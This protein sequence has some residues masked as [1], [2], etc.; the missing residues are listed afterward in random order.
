MSFFLVRSIF[1]RLHQKK[2]QSRALFK[3]LFC[4]GFRF[5]NMTKIKTSILFIRYHNITK[6]EQKIEKWLKKMLKKE[7]HNIVSCKY[8]DADFFIIKEEVKL[9]TE[10]NL[11][12]VVFVFGK[13]GLRKKDITLEIMKP[14]FDKRMYSF[15]HI[16][17][18]VIFDLIDS[19]AIHLR[20]MAGIKNETLIFCM[21]SN[22]KVF[23]FIAK[24]LIFPEVAKILETFE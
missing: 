13:I 3:G 2:E 14:L 8:I 9:I 16:V 18:N 15:E 19:N 22:H 1:I 23:K 20:N 12:D 10:N 21:P 4:S 6:E 5:K 7:K 24:V 11:S 17:S